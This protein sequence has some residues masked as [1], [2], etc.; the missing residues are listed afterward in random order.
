MRLLALA[1]VAPQEVNKAAIAHQVK[2]EQNAAAVKRGNREPWYMSGIGSKTGACAWDTTAAES[3][4]SLA[5][6]LK[7][8]R[9]KGMF[10]SAEGRAWDER[11]AQ[12]AGVVA[13]WG[14][15]A[16]GIKQELASTTGHRVTKEA[17]AVAASNVKNDPQHA[18]QLDRDEALALC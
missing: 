12:L 1:A 16:E 13:D 9:P 17:E 2:T 3:A 11:R 10:R 14:K 18:K 6:H 5:D 7:T 8:E 4:T 15:A